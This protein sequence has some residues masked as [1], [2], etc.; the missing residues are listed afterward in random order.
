LAFS[1][2]GRTL[3]AAGGN[4]TVVMW[5]RNGISSRHRFLRSLAGSTGAVAFSPDGRTLATASTDHQ[6]LL[7]D[8]ATGGTLAA[9]SGHTDTVTSIA[10]SRDS[11][12]LTT[13]GA[14]Q[15]VRVWNADLP[16]PATALSK[17]CR[18]I[19][20][21]LTTTEQTRYLPDQK[22]ERNS[23]TGCPPATRD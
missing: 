11:R 15:T 14:D 23:E 9:L 13:A 16:A 18:A 4:S 1:P 7:W 22:A 2:D 17:I 3:A 20:R 8:T 19:G 6:V 5:H 21:D 12:T 10:W